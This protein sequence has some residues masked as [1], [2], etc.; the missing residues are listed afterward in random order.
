MARVQVQMKLS[1]D[2]RDIRVVAWDSAAGKVAKIAKEV[3]L[4][5]VPDTIKALT[6]AC[7]G[8]LGLLPE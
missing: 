5:D 7:L 4:K 6:D 3:A 2:Y 8:E 1:R